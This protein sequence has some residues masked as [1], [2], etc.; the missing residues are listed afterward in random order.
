MPEETRPPHGKYGFGTH[1][2]GRQPLL[3]GIGD[4]IIFFSK[5]WS[6]ANI[7][8]RATL[9]RLPASPGATGEVRL[10]CTE[11]DRKEM[12]MCPHQHVLLIWPN[13]PMASLTL[14]SPEQK[15][16]GS[17]VCPD[18]RP[19][20]TEGSGVTGYNTSYLNFI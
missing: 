1:E 20:Q 14:R 11:T 8:L 17:Q 5:G 2:W 4:I 6:G 15:D 9:N 7:C 13:M 10:I 16:R 18:M 19:F 12:F 3:T